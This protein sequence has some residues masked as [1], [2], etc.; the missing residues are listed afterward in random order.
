MK[1]TFKLGDI[2]PINGTNEVELSYERILRSKKYVYFSLTAVE[3]LTMK[4]RVK[5][6]ENVHNLH[7]YDATRSQ[8]QTPTHSDSSATYLPILTI[9]HVQQ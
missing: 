1:I 7:E 6:E 4:L 3:K 9:K 5:S 8:F 2:I